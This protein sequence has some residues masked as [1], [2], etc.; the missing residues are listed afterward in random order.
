M[1]TDDKFINK[2]KPSVDSNYWLKSLDTTS[3]ETTNK[4]FIKFFVPTNKKMGL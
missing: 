4:I 2:Q 3:M 1:T